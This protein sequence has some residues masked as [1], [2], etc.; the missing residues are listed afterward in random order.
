M[1]QHPIYS[2]R[3]GQRTCV[4]ELGSVGLLPLACI[5]QRD[6]LEREVC[7]MKPNAKAHPQMPLLVWR[8]DTV[9][10]VLL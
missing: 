1:C 8:M 5:M 9:G 4:A 7:T 10:L 3:P 6:S 2:R